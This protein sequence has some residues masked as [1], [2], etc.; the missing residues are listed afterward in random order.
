M[1]GLRYAPP[2]TE[3]PSRHVG[4]AATL[5][6]PPRSLREG[7]A[8]RIAAEEAG[9]QGAAAAEA[10]AEP[11]VPQRKTFCSGPLE[12]KHGSWTL[13]AKEKRESSF[14]YDGMPGLREEVV[15]EEDTVG[16]AFGERNKKKGASGFVDL[17]EEAAMPMHL[18]LKDNRQGAMVLSERGG[19]SPWRVSCEVGAKDQEMDTER[20]KRLASLQ[21]IRKRTEE[22]VL[23]EGFE[24]DIL[25]HM[26]KHAHDRH[27]VKATHGVGERTVKRYKTESDGVKAGVN[28]VRKRYTRTI[29]APSIDPMLVGDDADHM[30]SIQQKKDDA[31]EKAAAKMRAKQEAYANRAA[32]DDD[33]SIPK[34]AGM[35]SLELKQSRLHSEGKDLVGR[36]A[37]EMQYYVIRWTDQKMIRERQK[38]RD[39]QAALRERYRQSVKVDEKQQDTLLEKIKKRLK[40]LVLGEK[41]V[42]HKRRGPT[43]QQKA[44]NAATTCFMI[45]DADQSG[46]LSM[47]E[48]LTAVKSDKRVLGFLKECKEKA[49]RDL[50]V[51]EKLQK[52][53]EEMD[54][55]KSGE[56][57]MDEWIAAVKKGLV[58][59][60]MREKEEAERVLREAEDNATVESQTLSFHTG[61]EP[62][63]VDLLPASPGEEALASTKSRLSKNSA[64]PKTSRGGKPPPAPSLFKRLFSSPVKRP[65]AVSPEKGRTS[66][67]S[68]EKAPSAPAAAAPMAAPAPAE[69]ERLAA[70]REAEAAS[71]ALAQRLEAEGQAVAAEDAKPQIDAILADAATTKHQKILAINRLDVPA[72]VKQKAMQAAQTP[73][74]KKARRG[75]F[76]SKT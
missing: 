21:S 4:F 64:R 52:G 54:S 55:D 59:E 17:S 26:L 68:P 40:R 9:E 50:L 36:E 41:A 39:A 34:P 56:I 60:E 13:S 49:L 1:M 43:R 51:P 24:E 32:T 37:Y 65:S 8:S 25:P 22:G 73:T 11:L 10:P 70:D 7:I 12:S 61:R 16:H 35:E 75:F 19:K 33:E 29:P 76:S 42:E 18:R 23:Q 58:E 28:S 47:D 69:Q 66:A 31:M 2:V 63:A 46:T 27:K 3:E 62:V 72:A 20:E 74:A 53:L 71:L 44:L 48:I 57:D 38:K 30:R 67:V 15:E 5:E 14:F 45:M 6:K